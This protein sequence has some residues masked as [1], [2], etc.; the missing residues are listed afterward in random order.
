MSIQAIVGIDPDGNI[1]VGEATAL[2]LAKQV[3]FP[4]GAT[5]MDGGVNFS[6]FADKA[7]ALEL[8]LFDHVEDARPGKSVV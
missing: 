8:L 4:L 1:G 7:H 3:S 6:V 5:P 2:E